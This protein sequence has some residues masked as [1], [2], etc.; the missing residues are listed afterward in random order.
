MEQK[1]QNEPEEVE[2]SNEEILTSG[3]IEKAVESEWRKRL[4]GI[5]ECWEEERWKSLLDMAAKK[6]EKCQILGQELRDEK[7]RCKRKAKR[8][9]HQV[10]H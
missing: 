3:S 8:E 5:R 1:G 4:L 6:Q 7:D 2:F 10:R 9:D